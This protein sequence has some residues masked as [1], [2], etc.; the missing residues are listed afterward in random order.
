MNPRISQY[1][2]PHDRWFRGHEAP[3]GARHAGRGKSL[4]L[5]CFVRRSRRCP[6]PRL[7]RHDPSLELR[8]IPYMVDIGNRP[9][10]SHLLD[11]LARSGSATAGSEVDL[12]Y[13][14]EEATD[15][16]WDSERIRSL[17]P[18]SLFRAR[19]G[20]GALFRY[21]DSVHGY[22]APFFL[23]MLGP[24]HDPDEGPPG[25]HDSSA[26]EAPPRRMPGYTFRRADGG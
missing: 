20:C 19:V 21:M 16:D 3:W 26:A 1:L 12:G 2:E 8:T 17:G 24:L 25:T 13:Q 5:E 7:L 18:Q 4:D 23:V 15:P 9:N 11:C 14:G 6:A 22:L 10:R